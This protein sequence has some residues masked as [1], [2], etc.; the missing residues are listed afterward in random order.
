MFTELSDP[1]SPLHDNAIAKLIMSPNK[2]DQNK[3]AS[4]VI[5]SITS[6]HPSGPF[7][8]FVNPKILLSNWQRHVETANKYNDPGKFTT[9]IAFE[10]TSIPDH[11]NMHRNVFF[12]GDT[13][14]EAPYSAFD[15]TNP[16]D[17]WTYM[18]V[19]RDLGL[20]VIAIP[21]NG[22]VSNGL[23]YAP[24]TYPRGDA[25]NARYAQRR[26]LN[27]PLTEMIQTKGASE[28]HPSLSPNDEFAD[29]E[30]FPHL[31][32]SPRGQQGQERLHSAGAD[33]GTDP[34]REARNQSRSSTASSP[35]RMCIRGT[36]GTRSSTGTA[37]TE[38]PTTPP[39]PGSTRSRTRVVSPAAIVGSA[40]ATAVWAEE[41]TRASIFDAMKRKGDL[42]NLGALDSFALLRRLGLRE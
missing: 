41:N 3:A 27:E 6:S 42:R 1:K 13:G 40:G 17:L 2:A 8:D 23:M 26:A 36:P 29:F 14:P 24:T 10:W 12:R 19:Q 33:R 20:D 15:S 30:M 34:R 32:G 7:L 9:L 22:N 37:L 5:E 28:T 31:I 25:I 4:L 21:H 11:Q 16:E 18:E 39:R 35:V 38:W